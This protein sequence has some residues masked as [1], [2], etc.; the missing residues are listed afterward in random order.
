MRR[1]PACRAAFTTFS[2]PATLIHDSASGVA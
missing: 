2:V 1:A